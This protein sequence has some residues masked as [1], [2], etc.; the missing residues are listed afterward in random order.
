MDD[1][2]TAPSAGSGVVSVEFGPAPMGFCF[3]GEDGKPFADLVWCKECGEA[4][5]KRKGC[6]IIECGGGDD[7][8]FWCDGCLKVVD[9]GYLTERGIEWVFEMFEESG[10]DGEC[11]EHAQILALMLDS[12][13]EKDPQRQ[14]AEA[15][16]SI[17]SGGLVR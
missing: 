11:L 8:V 14:T 17:A 3:A 12:M 2:K 5:A 9:T 10:P 13:T 4:A 16:F 6:R 15:W 1:Q 7:R